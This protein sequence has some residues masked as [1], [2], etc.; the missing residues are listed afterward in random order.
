MKISMLLLS[1]LTLRLRLTQETQLNV[2][3]LLFEL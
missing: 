3:Q 2:W 1:A